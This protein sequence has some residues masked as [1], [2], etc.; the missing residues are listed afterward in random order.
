[1]PRAISVILQVGD[2]SYDMNKMGLIRMAFNR[3]LDTQKNINSN[4][5]SNLEITMFDK[6]GS[7]LI[8][9]L[10]QNN[11]NILLKYGFE[12]DMSA[13]YKLNLLKY[14]ATYNNL[15]AMVSVGAYG[16]QINKKWGS[17]IYKQGETFRAILR[18]MARQNNWYIG[19][20]NSD[21]YINVGN[22]ALPRNINRGQN[23]TDMQFIINK[24]LPIAND[25]AYHADPSYTNFWDVKLTQDNANR[26]AFYF[27]SY[28]DRSTQRRL[29]KYE[30][31]SSNNNA[32]LSLT[33]TVDYSFLINGVSIQ[34]PASAS[35][36]IIP[37][38][39]QSELR[40]RSIISENIGQ[41]EDFISKAGLPY[42]D[43][44]NF[45][46]NVELI[47]A[48]NIGNV[49]LKDAVLNKIQDVMNAINTLELEVIGNPKIMP[50]DL[51]EIHVRNKDGGTNIISS[52][53]SV[54]SYWR[55]VKIQ[56]TIGLDGYITKLGLVRENIGK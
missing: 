42:I 7:E 50:S 12:D 24:L 20:S 38:G 34:V 2:T 37:E 13:V 31:G 41:I 6:T 55:I 8:A 49:T 35:D 33:N 45:I 22:L 51:I 44:N 46:W 27:R 9:L 32:I 53:S 21:E 36:I 3:F 52:N 10:Q 48:E 26:L 23:E 30:Y 25:S 19:G 29:W 40:I 14:K 5:L 56:E 54:G 43:P 1:M 39:E 17:K 47:E 16:I 18:E 15:G 4:V 11:N 28:K